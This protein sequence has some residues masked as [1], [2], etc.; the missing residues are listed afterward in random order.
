MT[1]LVAKG[2]RGTAGG[3]AGRVLAGLVDPQIRRRPPSATGLILDACSGGGGGGD[4]AAAS[5]TAYS[6][7]RNGANTSNAVAA[8]AIGE[9]SRR[10]LAMLSRITAAGAGLFDLPPTTQTQTQQRGSNSRSSSTPSSNKMK[11]GGGGVDEAFDDESSQAIDVK[12]I[13]RQ[14]GAVY[15]P[16]REKKKTVGSASVAR[17][18][19]SSFQSSSHQNKNSQSQS[20]T[21]LHL[22]PPTSLAELLERNRRRMQYAAAAAS[23]G[24]PPTKTHATATHNTTPSSLP[25]DGKGVPRKATLG[26]SPLEPSAL[27]SPV[28]SPTAFPISAASATQLPPSAAGSGGVLSL[29]PLRG[30]GLRG[31]GGMYSTPLNI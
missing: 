7:I 28:G 27:L 10:K 30:S 29:A 24:V 1:M 8:F 3:T 12:L 14:L 11:K 5:S 21:A 20:Q 9:K 19:S 22:P 26:I 31:G 15:Q 2:Q 16:F 23:G 6:A 25:A 17:A 4:S 13:S 18:N